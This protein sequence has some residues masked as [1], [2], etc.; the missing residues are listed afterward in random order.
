VVRRLFVALVAVAVLAA[1]GDNDPSPTSEPTYRAGETAR[2]AMPRPTP[3]AP[4]R[5][6][7]LGDSVMFD[8]APAIAAALTSTGA[9][10]VDSRPFLGFGL[11]KTDPFDW[12]KTWPE[13]L[14]EAAPGAV[15]VMI[16]AWDVGNREVAGRLL[17]LGQPAW[18]E[19]YGEIV[20]EAVDV[21]SANGAHVFWIGMP[22]AELPGG[23]ENATALNEVVRDVTDARREASF[24]DGASPL[25]ADGRFP[26]YLPGPDGT[27][28][29]IR[30]TDGIHLCPP[31]AARLAD[32]VA[33]R[34]AAVYRLALQPG[35]ETGVWTRDGRYLRREE[36]PD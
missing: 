17:I 24:L 33:G 36:C 12:R 34:I 21:L 16:G 2:L 8:A 1:C 18:R 31:G 14:A 10:I 11:T 3:A 4:L 9:M 7:I 26:Q 27:R 35:W 29:R 13:W 32:A 6:L 23:V 25:A 19:W 28:Q 5:V 22:G 20:E 30:K 15:V